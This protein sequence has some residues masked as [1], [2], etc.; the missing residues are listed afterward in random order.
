MSGW[1]GYAG[2]EE[3]PLLAAHSRVTNPERFLPL[4]T[5]MLEIIDRL[6]DDFNVECTEGFGLDEEL[7][8][9]MD[10]TRPDVKLTPRN[11]EAAPIVVAFS[12]FRGIHVRFGRW[13]TEP[14]PQ[15]GCDACDES[16]KG[17]I[18]R[19]NEMVD[20]VTAGR[21]RETIKAPLISFIGSGC[22]ARGSLVGGLMLTDSARERYPAGVA[23]WI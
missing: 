7:E 4:H 19:L 6:L 18:D 13:Y 12:T 1:F 10:G 2:G 15:C 16:A 21:F 5:A 22:L 11:P 23:D 20:D 9:G 14:F 3:S 8:R 17:E